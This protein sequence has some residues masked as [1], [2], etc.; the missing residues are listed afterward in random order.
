M[1][2]G[3]R[4]QGSDAKASKITDRLVKLGAVFFEGQRAENIGE[5][6]V[7][8][9]SSAIKKGNPELEEARRREAAGGAPG[10]DAGR[11]DAAASRTSPLPARMARPRRRRWW[12]PC[13]T[14]AALTRR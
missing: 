1:T 7:V 4:V 2:L 5:A 8:V 13:W 10:R 6:A 11:T 14:R 9:I 12:R 3:Y